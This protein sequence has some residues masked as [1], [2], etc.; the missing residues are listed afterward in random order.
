VRRFLIGV[1]AVAALA[2]AQSA[3]SQIVRA[4]TVFHSVQLPSG[5]TKA[6]TV[7]CPRGY[8]AVSA[9]VSS[10]ASG[11]TTLSIRPVGVRAFAFRFGNPSTNPK[12]RVTVAVACRRIKGTAAILRVVRVRSKSVV[13][14]AGGNKHFVLGCPNGTLPAGAGFNLG[15]RQLE[16]REQTQTPKRFAFTVQNNGGGARS[17]SF[18][19]IC[20][21]LLRPVG[22]P[23]AAL[24]V[25]LETQTT[26]LQPGPQ[27]V[28]R[29]CPA[30]WVPLATG[31]NL[32]PGVM[33][34][35][36]AA[37]GAGGRWAV[38]NTG[39]TQA[40]ADLQLACARVG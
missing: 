30:G 40:L 3:T 14:P 37:V 2:A 21:T 8:A 38:T 26:P 16:L 5:A 19:G 10:P 18:S 4:H 1:C 7:T 27:V 22:S 17:A 34:L 33:L 28:R 36:S 24:R 11:V 35:G 23:T 31:F 13:I 39:D 29:A 12:L 25:K 15:G 6:F 20:L 32:R 9:G